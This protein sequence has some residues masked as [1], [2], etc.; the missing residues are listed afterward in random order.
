MNNSQSAEIS[1]Y[2]GKLLRDN[3]GKGPEGVYVSIGFTFITIYIRNFITPIE[4][5]LLEQKNLAYVEETRDLVMT[6]IIPEIK[7]N[8]YRITG[9]EVMEFYY[10]WAMHNKSATFVCICSDQTQSN[11]A[12]QSTF[13]GKE[14][15]VDEIIHISSMA[16]K[17][18][19]EISAYMLNNRTYVFIR[20]GILVNIEK[21]L[22]RDGFK[23][24]LKL[25]KRRL[26][27]R[28][29]HNNGHWEEYLNSKII[30]IFVD[31]DFE[32]D[33]SIM[34]FITNPTK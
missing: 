16:Q 27:K 25:A 19:E 20:N 9:M 26:E 6:T 29:L 23:E 11:Q 21:E 12:L 24:N 14:K 8:I 28:Y 17:A 10:D 18:P 15:M 30:D 1:N 13:H 32:I 22:I 34:L 4:R 5:V 33:K 7:A 2:V 3:F 31:W